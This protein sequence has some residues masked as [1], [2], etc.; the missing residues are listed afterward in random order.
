MKIVTGYS[1]SR[2][3]IFIRINKCGEEKK[4]FLHEYTAHTCY[5]LRKKKKNLNTRGRKTGIKIQ[6]LKNQTDTDTFTPPPPR[7]T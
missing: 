2:V 4:R 1:E 3:E 5:S 7:H 6:E